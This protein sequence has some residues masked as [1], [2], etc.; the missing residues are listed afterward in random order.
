MYFFTKYTYEILDRYR[1]HVPWE[2]T[3]AIGFAGIALERPPAVSTSETSDPLLLFGA[4]VDFVNA[5]VLVRI[6][7]ISPQ[8]EWMGDNSQI[9]QDTPVHAIA[10]GFSQVMPVLPLIEPFFLMPNGKIQMQFTNDQSL[11]VT[12]GR[13]TWR[14]LR[15]VDPIEGGW[16][17]Q[18]GFSA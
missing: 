8:Y 10:G 17:Y 14:G 16:N 4:A 11:P 9:P 3:V 2:D 12:G 15:L 18:M 1:K 5:R 13:W 6:K 7:S